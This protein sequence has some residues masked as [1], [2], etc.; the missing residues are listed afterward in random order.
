MKII[1]LFCLMTIIYRF[2]ETGQSQNSSAR[3]LNEN[4]NNEKLTKKINSKRTLT[5]HFT[6]TFTTSFEQNQKPTKKIKQKERKAKVYS[7]EESHLSVDDRKLLTVF[8]LPHSSFDFSNSITD[9]GLKLQVEEIK[10]FMRKLAP[11]YAKK[12]EK[13]KSYEDYL[14]VAKKRLHSLQKRQIKKYQDWRK[15]TW[16]NIDKVLEE[17]Q[18]IFNMDQKVNVQENEK[19]YQVFLVEDASKR[20]HLIPFLDLESRLLEII[21]EELVVISDY[22]SILRASKRLNSRHTMMMNRRFRMSFRRRQRQHL[23]A[24]RQMHN[25]FIKDWEINQKFATNS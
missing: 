2:S 10:N 8:D 5:K 14:K 25:G 17:K 20:E 16:E 15:K 11:E 1:L 12:E 7:V 9:Q 18:P 24:M 23:R 21:E 3:E 4:S 13:K 19:Y 6:S 22:K